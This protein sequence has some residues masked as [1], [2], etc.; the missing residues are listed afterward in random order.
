[1]KKKRRP[2]PI[3][4]RKRNGRLEIE[5]IGAWYTYWRDPYHLVLT[6]P[7]LGFLALIALGYV[8]A[9]AVFAL[10]YL[11]GGN[12]IANA[13]PGN[14]LDAFFFS[15][16]TM[17]SIGYGVMY[18]NT[19][20]ANAVV[21]IEAL[22]G[23]LGLAMSSGLAL[24]RFSRPTARVIFS[25]V[26]VVAPHNGIPTLMFRTANQRRNLILEAQLQLR[27]MRDEV[28]AEGEFMRRVYDLQLIDRKSVV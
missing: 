17:A 28:N 1:M 20:Y 2:S 3:R 13:R 5:G 19:T 9:N 26:A 4:I 10:V 18:P 22:V 23:L 21:A 27:L 16:Q 25:R 15:V 12:C 7:W 24:A 14:F 8:V 11:A 6:I